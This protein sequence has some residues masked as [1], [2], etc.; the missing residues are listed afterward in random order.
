MSLSKDIL[1]EALTSTGSGVFSFL[2]GG[3]TQIFEQIVSIIV[4][5][6]KNTNLVASRSFKM[7]K[8]SL[9]V[10]VR[11]TKTPLLWPV[12]KLSSKSR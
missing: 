2:D 12:L 9:P 10:K 11:S 1:S 6:L 4:K 3:F 8:T 5:T 7:K